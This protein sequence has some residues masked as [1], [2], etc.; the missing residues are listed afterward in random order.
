[1]GPGW[2]YFVLGGKTQL[3]GAN[4]APQHLA[5]VRYAELAP[6]QFKDLR[7]DRLPLLSPTAR[8]HPDKNAY[9]QCDGDSEQRAPLGFLQ[10]LAH[11]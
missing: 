5:T 10:D 2:L 6:N 9:A 7:R 8:C 4:G 3:L 1:M 11:C